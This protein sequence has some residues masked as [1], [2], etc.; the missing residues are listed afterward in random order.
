MEKRSVQYG[1]I[2]FS[3]VS[4]FLVLFLVDFGPDKF[5]AEIVAA[6]TISMAVLWMTEVIPLSATSL[7][8]LIIFPLFG[9][10]EANTIA[11]SYINST[12]FLFIGGFIIALAM[13]KWNLHKRVALTVILWFGS[14]PS[15]VVL[16]FMIAT[17][18]ISMW[19]SNTATA[20]MVLPIGLA[21]M[22]KLEDEYG[23]EDMLPFSKALMLGIA[24]ACTIGGIAT[25]IGTPP[26]LVFL[27]V[28][29]ISFPDKPPIL[30]GEWIKIALPISIVMLII[31]WYLI[32][33]VF[34]PVKKGLEFDPV[35][36]RKEKESLGK[37]TYE[38]KVVM[39]VFVITSLL[40]LFRVELDLG[41]VKIPGWSKLLPHYK[42]I[43]DG[44]V[45]IMMAFLLFILP[46]NSGESKRGYIIDND[47][48]RK[49]PWDIILLFGG[50]FAIAEGFIKSRLSE[51]I[52]RQFIA[53][54]GFPL[55]VIIGV[56]CLVITFLSEVTSNTATAQIAL[57][58]LASLAIQINTDPLLIMIP[59]TIAASMGFMLP[60]STPPNAII[61]SSE[62]L[63]IIDMVKPGIFLDFICIIIITLLS[64]F[65]LTL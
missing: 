35:I 10:L 19:I 6:A 32:A 57:P 41:F 5:N 61:F 60:I 63:K 52:G 46:T 51:I 13:E 37:T 38:E 42:L 64:Y 15:G 17:A 53:L 16:G 33:K 59:A 55:I 20:L 1:I 8:P 14:S 9:V 30:F 11:Q 24:F 26:N 21:I 40:W 3:I 12:I 31:F 56:I 7:I 62:R 28:Y 25:L 48:I 29:S 34:Y 4:F 50:G 58:V 43:D 27:R 44:T 18:F 49:V 2:S 65:L 39:T 54:N 22:H 36:L 23:K 45:A 47:V